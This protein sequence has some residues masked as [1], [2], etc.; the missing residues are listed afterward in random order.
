MVDYATYTL[1]TCVV[2]P[3]LIE[4]TP[5]PDLA[6]MGRLSYKVVGPSVKRPHAGLIRKVIS[7]FLLTFTSNFLWGMFVGKPTSLSE[8]ISGIIQY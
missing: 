1:G 7:S 4:W 8:Q 3:A 2:I 6:W 5:S